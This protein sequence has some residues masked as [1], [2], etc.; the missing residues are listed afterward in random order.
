MKAM[1]ATAPTTRATSTPPDMPPASEA[2]IRAKVKPPSASA[3]SA[4]PRRSSLPV[5]LSSRDSGTWRGA[6]QKTK[7]P[8]GRL[9]RKIAR[10]STASISQ[11]PI[12][13]PIAAATPPSAD[14]AP[15]ARARSSGWKEDSISA[16]LPGVSRAPPTPWTT[17]A[18]TSTPMLGASEQSAEAVVNQTTP[19]MKIRRR[20]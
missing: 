15:I 3:A 14:Q 12:S 20:P 6:A 7:A 19:S 4:E 11:P 18:A 13:G 1:L 8:S 17:R 10:Q 9:I 2:L 16:R 5:T